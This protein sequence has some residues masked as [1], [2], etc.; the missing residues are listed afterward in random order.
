M[1]AS[2]DQSGKADAA[3][4]FFYDMEQL[5]MLHFLPINATTAFQKEAAA[6]NLALRDRGSPFFQK[7][8]VL[9]TDC[10]Q[11]TAFIQK[12]DRKALPCWRGA[13]EAFSC[14]TKVQEA[15]ARGEPVRIAYLPLT[16]LD[17]V[18]RLANHA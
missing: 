12:G 1:D 2:S 16:Q 17:V 8:K 15:V 9:Y 3:M 10:Q 6:L 11:L 14:L 5:Q 4:T 7:S 18:H 13:R